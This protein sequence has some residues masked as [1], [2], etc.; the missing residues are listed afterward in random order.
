MYKLY[1]FL[2]N[3]GDAFG[4]ISTGAYGLI[5]FVAIIRPPIV[6]FLI[7]AIVSIAL[8]IPVA[9]IVVIVVRK[10]IES[11]ISSPVF[12]ANPC[13][14]S[15]FPE[16]LILIVHVIRASLNLFRDLKPKLLISIR[17]KSNYIKMYHF[18]NIIAK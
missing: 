5:V 2:K 1:F 15:S 9:P 17:I 16:S 3:S 4:S 12:T 13:V 14:T 7:D 8:T 18:V 11:V 6:C 10:I